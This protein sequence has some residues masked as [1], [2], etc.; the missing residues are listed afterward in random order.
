M[1]DLGGP[2]SGKLWRYAELSRLII[3]SSDGAPKPSQRHIGGGIW[4]FW[5]DCRIPFLYRGPSKNFD[6]GDDVSVT[7]IQ[8]A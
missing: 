6:G 5:R 4:M 1:A 3:S 2:A 8:P 7:H